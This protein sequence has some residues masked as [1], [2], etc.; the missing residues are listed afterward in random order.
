MSSCQGTF[1]AAR[2]VDAAV[3]GFLQPRLFPQNPGS[4]RRLGSDKIAREGTRVS[5]GDL[6]LL[7]GTRKHTGIC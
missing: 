5:A 3:Q 4:L 1:W 2:N 6:Y 7:A